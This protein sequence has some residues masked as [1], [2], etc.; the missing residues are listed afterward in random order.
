MRLGE[1]DRNISRSSETL[2]VIRGPVP[3]SLR[4]ADRLASFA[5][6][7]APVEQLVRVEEVI[8]HPEYSF[9]KYYDIALLKLSTPVSWLLFYIVYR[10]FF[11]FLCLFLFFS[12]SNFIIK[13]WRT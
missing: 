8:R 2:P 4:F 1:H 6:T 7:N 13:A 9:F 11:R 5:N 3:Q 10:V 12:M